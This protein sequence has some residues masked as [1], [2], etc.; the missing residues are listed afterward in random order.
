MQPTNFFC[1]FCL[2]RILGI[3]LSQS[4]SNYLAMAYL[5]I[6]IMLTAAAQINMQIRKQ[7]C[8]PLSFKY[9]AY[10]KIDTGG[11]IIRT[12][13]KNRQSAFYPVLIR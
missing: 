9:G 1:I 8:M 4:F 5:Y 7:N 10:I 2:P 12:N 11:Q 13:N 3:F 6:F